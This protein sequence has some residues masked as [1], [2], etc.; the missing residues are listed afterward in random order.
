MVEAM[1][2]RTPV[3][4]TRIGG[5]IDAVKHEETG[6]L[7]N[8]RAPDEIAAAVERLVREPDL[9]DRLMTAGHN[10]ART[11]FTR[12]ASVKAFSELFSTLLQAS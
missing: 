10:L 12:S 6:L 11:K 7:V 5:I 4:A 3:I 2:A 9:A 1:L 8:E